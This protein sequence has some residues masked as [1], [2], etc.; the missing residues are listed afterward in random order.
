[1]SDDQ[2]EFPEISGYKIQ[3]K[4]GQG[5]MATVFLAMQ[6]SF[7]RLVALKVLAPHL[8]AE[9]D[10]RKRF[11]RE[12]QTAA[13]L[14]HQS[15]VPVYDFGVCGDYH[16]IAMEFLPGGS[17]KEKMDLGLSLQEAISITKAI[18]KGLD[19][20]GRKGLVHRDIK[21]ENI[22]FR[23]DGSPVISDFGIA[24]QISANTNITML[25]SVVGTPR[26]MSPEQAQGN[27]VDPRSDL[28]SL[29]TI[30]YELLV[31]KAPFISDS[32]ISV[33][34]KHI[35]ELPPP[36]PPELSSLQAIVDHILEKDPEK[37]F[38]TGN[39]FVKA[40]AIAEESLSASY[41]STVVQNISDTIISQASRQISRPLTLNN[42][43]YQVAPQAVPIFK[44]PWVWLSGLVLLQII[45]F[46]GWWLS[47]LSHQPAASSSSAG[48]TASNQLLD[49]K[50]EDLLEK[51]RQAM[52]TEQFVE[53]QGDNAQFY[54]TSLLTLSP[55]HP[56]GRA[57]IAELYEHYLETA[58]ALISGNALSDAERH[59]NLASQISYYI[60]EPGALTRLDKLYQEVNKVRLQA[61][62]GPSMLDEPPEKNENSFAE[63]SSVQS[64]SVSLSEGNAS[65]P[66]LV[67]DV[68]AADEI[69]E[70]PS[71][72]L[73]AWLD[74][75]K[76]AMQ[77][78]RLTKPEDGS[79]RYYYLRVLALSPD[80]T[81]ALNGLKEIDDYYVSRINAALQEQSLDRAESLLS[82][83]RN[84]GPQAKVSEFTQRLSQYRALASIHKLDAPAAGRSSEL[85]K[86]SI[87][88]LLAD[89]DAINAQKMNQGTND[90]LRDHYLAILLQDSQH[91]GARQGLKKTSD[92]ELILAEA[93]LR[94]KRYDD[95]YE[96]IQKIQLST[97]DYKLGSFEKRLK[98]AVSSPEEVNNRLAKASDLIRQPYVKPGWLE[99][100]N[101]ARTRLKQAY[102]LLDQ[103]RK[104]KAKDF[105][106]EEL[107]Q[108]LD[109]KYASIVSGLLLDGDVTGSEEF[110]QDTRHF[111]WPGTRLAFVSSGILLSHPT[112]SVKDQDAVKNAVSK[113]LEDARQLIAIPYI[114]P[115]LLESNKE[116]RKRLINAYYKVNSARQLMPGNKETDKVLTDLDDKYA[117]IVG[118]LLKAGEQDE[119][120]KFI[121]DTVPF[122]W[123]GT[124]LAFAS[125]STSNE[126]SSGK[127]S[128]IEGA[129]L[130]LVNEAALLIE[131]PYIRPGLFES[132]KDARE[133]LTEAYKKLDAARRLSPGESSIY[134]QLIMLDEKYTNIVQQLI[135]KNDRKEALKFVNDTSHFNWPGEKLAALKK[136][137]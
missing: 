94:E 24:R 130:K 86:K 48:L 63:E 101:D 71:L 42:S 81:E 51:A 80:N 128:D 76:Q 72:Q 38:Q 118:D 41:R 100:N 4:L 34:I 105:R 113:L 7:E 73:D 43:A 92:F 54:L 67:Q 129:T 110:L 25:G 18:A 19:Y 56:E 111:N 33:S 136:T 122:K 98:K 3:K 1:M 37:R 84:F 29:G 121:E 90:D 57:L 46:S 47:Q 31:G 39:E 82:N 20:A 97:P 36:L 17:L 87:S 26:Y 88:T 106:V 83:Y 133:R 119:A 109:E 16:Y 79:A 9:E 132:N 5:G 2:R 50:A 127:L 40:L 108:K 123:Q 32:A 112:A 124:K 45:L 27:E 104:T 95:A 135:S 12:A 59:I 134:F 68:A 44:Q 117:A 137:L 64:S 35:T 61:S 96:H 89:I 66:Q 30:F 11:I 10:F 60:A 6:E 116:P 91:Q 15:I 22:L 58:Q 21:P 107:L 77:K 69:P 23:E 102:G 70:A 93:A 126:G 14:S 8:V 62:Q 65:P 114:R 99:N 55:E 74:Q 125:A 131:Q 78:K 120:R 103:V 49:K 28:Y 53:P 13:K 52:Q 75:A 85:A 115:G